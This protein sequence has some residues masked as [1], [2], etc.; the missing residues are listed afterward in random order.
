[1]ACA[2]WEGI[3][4]SDSLYTWLQQQGDFRFG[5]RE[6][7]TLFTQTQSGEM[8]PTP[9]EMGAE[10]SHLGT[11][12]TPRGKPPWVSPWRLIRPRG[13]RGDE[14]SPLSPA[15]GESFSPPL[16]SLFRVFRVFR[17][18]SLALLFRRTYG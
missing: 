8:I 13:R 6:T 18:Q 17:G 11:N 4:H 3:G 15:A 7:T 12:E 2:G 5:G 16:S 9:A 1:M 10:G 14:V